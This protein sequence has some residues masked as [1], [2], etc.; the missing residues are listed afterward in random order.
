M[1][2][3]SIVLIHIYEKDL[4]KNFKNIENYLRSFDLKGKHVYIFIRDES[5][6]NHENSF[7]ENMYT[8]INVPKVP[9]LLKN[10]DIRELGKLKT[11]GKEIIELHTKIPKFTSRN[12][13]QILKEFNPSL[14]QEI[15]S[16]QSFLTAITDSIVKTRTNSDLNFEFLN[17]YPT[18]VKLMK[19]KYE[20]L[21]ENN[22]EKLEE[23][24]TQCSKCFN[25]LNES[26][27]CPVVGEIFQNI[28]S[29]ADAV[30][31]LWKLAQDLQILTNELSTKDELKEQANDKYSIEILWREA[32]LSQKY[33]HKN[34]IGSGNRYHET[35]SRSLSSFIQTGEP[36]ELIDGDNLVF[37][38]KELNSMFRYFHVWLTSFARRYNANNPDNQITEA[39]LV[40]SI[41]GPQSSGKSTLL[42]YVFGCKFLTSTGRCTRGVYGSLLEL[43][44]PIN[45]S[46]FL[47]VLD[48]ES[49]D[50]VERSS[51]IHFDRTLIVF[52][53]SVSN[54]VIINLIGELNNEMQELMKICADSSFHNMSTAS[55]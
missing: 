27:I 41:I 25:I 44:K 14:Y 11:I 13:E 53:L 29:H 34:N 10:N 19:K 12:L 33:F 35:L 18:F 24:Y 6:G 38:S 8:V 2:Q 5:E 31:I 20:I 28:I 17:F 26:K 15:M 3:V 30:L 21:S 4:I 37:F 42:N 40:L 36:F 1:K 47:L 43:N 51:A 48:T 16:K 54:V 55:A 39:P 49:I 32:I 23:L 52:C 50:S 7:D 46:K 22:I 9:S 45:R